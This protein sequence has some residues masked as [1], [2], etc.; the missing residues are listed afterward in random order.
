MTFH[1]HIRFP[2]YRPKIS[3][4]LLVTRKMKLLQSLIV[5][6]SIL[7]FLAQKIGAYTINRPQQWIRPSSTELRM[8]TP[9]ERGVGGSRRRRRRTLA[10]RTQQDAV[11]LIRDIIQTAVEAGPRAGPTRTF[12]AYLAFSQT[13]REFFPLPGQSVPTFSVPKVLR[14]FP[15]RLQE[16]QYT[17]GNVNETQICLQTLIN[18]RFLYLNN[19]IFSS[20][21][22][23]SMNLSD[24][25]RG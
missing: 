3:L 21:Q 14:S 5:A 6:N 15:I 11:G 8:S 2:K 24:T 10:D 9:T 4:R 19:D 12:Q 7:L 1:R 13:F 18:A 17:R 22:L 16:F 23:G 25:C 20:S